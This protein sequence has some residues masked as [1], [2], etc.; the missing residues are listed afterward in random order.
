MSFA[1]VFPMCTTAAE[2]T[3]LLSSKFTLQAGTPASCNIQNHK[4]CAVNRDGKTASST[5][6]P[7]SI[8]LSCKWLLSN[9]SKHRR[10]LNMRWFQRCSACLCLTQ[11]K[12]HNHFNITNKTK[13]RTLSCCR[14]SWMYK[15]WSWQ[16]S[17]TD[18]SQN[19]LHVQMIIHTSFFTLPAC[20]F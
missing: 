15:H 19:K 7:H 3:W 11:H 13:R 8:Y 20:H 14:L 10:S 18:M 5:S 9:L 16:V 4:D 1:G 12:Q 6:K 2:N 17:K